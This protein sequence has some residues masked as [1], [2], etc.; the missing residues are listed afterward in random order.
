MFNMLGKCL[1][2]KLKKQIATLLEV[3]CQAIQSTIKTEV[4]PT[5]GQCGSS[6]MCGS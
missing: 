6:V 3:T 1:A 5:P 2:N 4:T